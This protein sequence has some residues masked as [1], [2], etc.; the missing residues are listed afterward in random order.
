MVRADGV[1]ELWSHSAEQGLERV[2]E[3]WSELEGVESTAVKLALA[4]LG[5]G[6][7]F[8]LAD[9]A[10]A[11]SEVLEETGL[12]RAFFDASG[13]S[14]AGLYAVR[15]PS[16]FAK[17]LFPGDAV[18]FEDLVLDGGKG[19][20]L[21]FGWLWQL[22]QRLAEEYS[23]YNEWPPRTAVGLV[24]LKGVKPEPLSLSVYEVSYCKHG[25]DC[26]PG[27]SPLHSPDMRPDLCVYISQLDAG[28]TCGIYYDAPIWAVS[29]EE[30]DKDLHQQ[31]AFD[32]SMP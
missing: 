28:L 27:Y 32:P 18:Y 26:G 8:T 9:L 12:R 19:F 29:Q 6:V 2:A 3:Q 30:L 14:E 22:G 7:I 1:F 16:A 20:S 21:P 15:D 31:P 5:F 25:A 10:H 24:T 17:V 11:T 13:L 4:P 23:K